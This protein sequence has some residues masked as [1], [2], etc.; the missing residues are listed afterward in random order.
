MRSSKLKFWQVPITEKLDEMLK[1]AIRENA[2]VSKSD[3]IREAVRAKLTH[4]GFMP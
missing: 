4:D 3:Y 1:T 2:H